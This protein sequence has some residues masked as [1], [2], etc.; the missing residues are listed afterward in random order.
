M[1]LEPVAE[2]TPQHACGRARGTALHHEVLPIKEIRG[3]TG[4]K[5]KCLEP[6]KGRERSA[7]PF[8]AIPHEIGDPEVAVA[9]GIRSHGKRVPALEIKIAMPCRRRIRAPRIRTFAAPASAVSGAMPLR[10]ARQFLSYPLRI[11]GRFIVTD[12]DRTVERQ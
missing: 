12:V 5:R 8:P 6:G 10:F 11:G 2:R 9:L 1:R 3:I 4:I 7:R